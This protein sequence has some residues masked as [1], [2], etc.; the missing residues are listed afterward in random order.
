MSTYKAYEAV[1]KTSGKW[2]WKTF[3][4]GSRHF[5]KYMHNYFKITLFLRELV[6]IL[7]NA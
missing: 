4:F 5:L 6:E 3:Y 1:Q 7:T 2:N